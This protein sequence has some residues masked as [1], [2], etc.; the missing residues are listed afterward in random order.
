MTVE[1]TGVRHMTGGRKV[2]GERGQRWWDVIGRGRAHVAMMR[3]TWK[4]EEQ[5]SEDKRG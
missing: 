4:G 1:V 3:T 2:I 5:V